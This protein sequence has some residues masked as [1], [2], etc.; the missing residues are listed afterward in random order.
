MAKNMNYTSNILNI[1]EELYKKALWSYFLYKKAA[2]M[3]EI[4]PS[5]SGQAGAPMG[6]Y[7]SEDE[8]EEYQKYNY[9]KSDYNSLLSMGASKLYEDLKRSE[10]KDKFSNYYNKFIKYSSELETLRSNERRLEQLNQ[11]LST[12]LNNSLNERFNDLNN[13]YKNVTK[14]NY[15][16][17]ALNTNDWEENVSPFEAERV[18]QDMYGM[19]QFQMFNIQSK[20]PSYLDDTNRALIF[21]TL[22]SLENEDENLNEGEFDDIIGIPTEEI[23]DIFKETEGETA[24]D[25]ENRIQDYTETLRNAREQARHKYLQKL[26]T[27]KKLNDEQKELVKAYKKELAE[28]PS[29]KKQLF[30]KYRE[31]AERNKQLFLLTDYGLS[32]EIRREKARIRANEHLKKLKEDASTGD[33]EAQKKLKEHRERGS[34][35]TK[36]HKDIEG[37][38]KELASK[39][40]LDIDESENA[41]VEKLFS[42][43]RDEAEKIDDNEKRNEF[44]NQVKALEEKKK[45]IEKWDKQRIIDEQKKHHEALH[46]TPEGFKDFSKMEI[47]GYVVAFEND[48]TKERNEIKERV[49]DQV[50][51]FIY[52]SIDSNNFEK[53]EDLELKRFKKQEETQKKVNKTKEETK[54][55]K[56]MEDTVKDD[57]NFKMYE[58]LLK[59]IAASTSIKQVNENII[60][61]ERSF[62]EAFEALNKKIQTDIENK[63]TEE[64]NNIINKINAKNNIIDIN[65][66]FNKK[67]EEINK[68]IED[69]ENWIKYELEY[70]LKKDLQEKIKELQE[71]E[72]GI[73][74][75]IFARDEFKEKIKQEVAKTKPIKDF[76]LSVLASRDYAKFF[77]MIRDEIAPIEEKIK[78]EQTL[79]SDDINKIDEALN[80]G[81]NLIE[82]YKNKFFTETPTPL[83]ETKYHKQNR[84]ILNL[85]I[86][87]SNLRKNRLDKPTKEQSI[88]AHFMSGYEKVK[89]Y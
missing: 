62:Q 80:T 89:K 28:N 45:T 68:Y 12:E 76:A 36:K 19:F 70:A 55:Y 44:L 31:I 6:Y 9:D 3:V 73:S 29:F 53:L 48:I 32:R 10:F 26:K 51:K 86:Y 56:L 27:Y 66:S 49:L 13:A 33:P 1:S 14:D 64:I 59:N 75:I 81:Y 5:S 7:S 4:A 74:P 85:I 8:D 50:R 65:F 21:T 87:L 22:E 18:M 61:V 42:F 82:K 46:I 20:I 47:A 41:T 23:N 24:Q 72:Q 71:Q 43:V 11:E 60:A 54:L 69:S 16:E 88:A 30:Q 57:P 38:L 39:I 40:G 34:A 78:N 17:Q 67:V 58:S 77:L 37:A 83:R 84:T 52:E 2:R 79:E 63:N 25:T 15:Y 35:R